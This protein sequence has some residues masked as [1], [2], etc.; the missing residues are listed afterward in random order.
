MNLW[1]LNGRSHSKSQKHSTMSGYP[2]GGPFV[3]TKLVAEC[4][5][6]SVP[7][8]TGTDSRPDITA[9]PQTRDLACQRSQKPSSRL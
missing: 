7:R 8:W 5:H 9:R 2:V 1:V 4:D 3:A 6:K